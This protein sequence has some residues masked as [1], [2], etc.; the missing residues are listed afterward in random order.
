MNADG[1][2]E[3]RLTYNESHFDGNPV[4]SPDGSKLHRRPA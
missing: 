2:G 3:T 4:F 1:S